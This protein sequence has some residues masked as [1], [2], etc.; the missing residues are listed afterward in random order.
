MP[1]SPLGGE[2]M[3]S[4]LAKAIINRLGGT[5]TPP[6]FGIEHFTVGLDP[7]LGII[8]EE[9]LDSFIK[10]GGS[11]FK[12]VIGNYGGGKTHF[13]YRIRDV[14][15]AR[16]YAVSY[17]A[18]SPVECPFNK[19]E[20]VY[21]ATVA[22]LM[23]PMKGE[24]QIKPWERGIDGFLRNWYMEKVEEFG[25]KGGEFLTSYVRSIAGIESSS[26]TNAVREA[27]LSL[28][29][30]GE[31]YERILQWLKGEEIDRVIRNKYG[32]T[33][34]VDKTTAFRHLRS[35][36]Q[37]I[38]AIGYAGL[39]L[40]FDEA[41]RGLSIASSRERR[42]A[43]DNLRQLIDECGNSRLPGVMIFYAIPDERQLLEERLEVYEALRQRLSG[44]L[45]GVNPSGVRINLEELGKEPV[46]FLQELGE[47]LSTIY[48]DAYP[49]FSFP[50]E[51][52]REAI[53]YLAQAAYEERYADVGHRRV[54][55][56][57]IIQAFHRLRN[58]PTEPIGRDMARRIIRDQLMALEMEFQEEADQQEY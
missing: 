53:T 25:E 15:W 43:M 12:L 31:D 58:Q 20:L 41:E 11:A 9:Y 36:A 26:F 24:E 30:G 13:L 23:H 14:A 27:F 4:G 34:R 1:I 46:E 3:K 39:V 47:K 2:P 38:K 19:L 18:L 35:L 50:Q 55:V 8:D 42:V 40:L 10:L 33:E 52:L 21:K 49:P 17:V 56:K 32:I 22:N 29:T 44:V 16:G 57:G 54:F 7:W 37:W 6:E 5:G 48:Q 45:T 28:Q 51:S